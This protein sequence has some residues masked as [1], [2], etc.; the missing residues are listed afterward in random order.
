MVAFFETV[1]NDV[2]AEGGFDV[3]TDVGF[4]VAGS[5]LVGCGGCGDLAVECV[6]VLGVDTDAGCV[7]NLLDELIDAKI[8]D[9]DIVGV[10]EWIENDD[11]IETTE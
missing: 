9:I 10:T 7:V 4:D 3:A 1:A 6:I 2:F 8:D 11:I 5:E